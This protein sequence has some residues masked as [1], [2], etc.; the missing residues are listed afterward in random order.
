MNHLSNQ[1][2]LAL[3]R[4]LVDELAV[5]DTITPQLYA[6][7]YRRCNNYDQ[8]KYQIDLL[9]QI[10]R[11][12]GKVAQNP[13]V[14][15]ASHLA[16]GPAQRAGWI[17]VYDFLQRGYTALR[18]IRKTDKFVQVIEQRETTI[19]ERIYHHHPDPFGG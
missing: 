17:E 9:T 14:G 5:T 7:G 4:V 19:L 8:R 1:L 15:P 16:R 12:V 6:E 13:L 3:L 18:K 2:D 10:L 11:E